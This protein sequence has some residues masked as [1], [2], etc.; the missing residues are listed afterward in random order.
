MSVA[1]AMPTVTGRA[2]I[3]ILIRYVTLI[4]VSSIK[5]L[6]ARK[7]TG[8]I[9]LVSS[10]ILFFEAV[11]NDFLYSLCINITSPNMSCLRNIYFLHPLLVPYLANADRM[12]VAAGIG[13]LGIGASVLILSKRIT[14]SLISMAGAYILMILG[15]IL[16]YPSCLFDYCRI[17]NYIRAFSYWDGFMLSVF[18]LIG[19]VMY[20][21]WRIFR[22]TTYSNVEVPA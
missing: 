3:Q 1:L 8:I 22:K 6:N 7:V 15:F 18:V 16:Y 5:T 2:V 20:E 13:F 9:A 21:S 11:M 17:T 19:C 10:S 14:Y 12:G 4:S